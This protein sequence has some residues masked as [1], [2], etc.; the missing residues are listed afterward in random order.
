[1]KMSVLVS[2]QRSDK[3]PIDVGLHDAIAEAVETAI[4]A[5]ELEPVTKGR[6]ANQVEVPISATVEEYTVL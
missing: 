3:R 2:I 6:G 4:N 5:I 1:M